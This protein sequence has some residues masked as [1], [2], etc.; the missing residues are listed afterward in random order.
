MKHFRPLILTMKIALA[1][2]FLLVL[3]SN[4][5]AAGSS[6]DRAK[7]RAFLEITGFDV[8]IESLQQ[9]A[10][11]GPGLA[12]DAPNEFG[13]E[14]VRLAEEI[15]A[16][17]EMIERT[18]DMMEAIMPE[19]LVDH[20]A[21]FY[22]SDLGQRL[23]AIENAAHMTP[24]D[25]KYAEAEKIVAALIEQNS[26]RLD[27]FKAMNA[28][29]GGIEN[30]VRSVIEIQARYFLAAMAAG[31]MDL[32]MSEADLRGMLNA[33]ADNIRQNV[34]A[35]AVLGAA[36]AYRDLSDED[37]AAYVTALEHP[38]MRQVYE[39]LNAIQFEVMAERYERLA[40]ALA[41]LA[42]QQDI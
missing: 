34:K 9:G 38:K 40:T 31:S 32:D 36:F 42:P 41:G 24:D 33:Q 19:D 1:A 2:A 30:S 15:F 5:F 26:P 29:V 20:G 17:D 18:L 12:G 39:I 22:A 35:Y 11:A 37:L 16:P 23:V 4:S 7:L 8:A 27:A 14:W 13:S 28:A 25:I 21:A 10:M 3:T 6:A